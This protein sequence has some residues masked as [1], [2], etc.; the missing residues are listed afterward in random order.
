MVEKTKQEP[1]VEEPRNA[2]VV[3]LTPLRM[4]EKKVEEPKK[5]EPKI[6][7]FEAKL[8]QLEE[9]GF[10]DRPRNVELLVKCNGDMVSVVRDLLE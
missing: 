7:A 10:S 5:E 2:T 6:S 8:Q 9:M 1:T 3:P 4:V